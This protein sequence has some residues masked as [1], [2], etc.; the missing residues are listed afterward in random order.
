MHL[1]K[2]DNLTYSLKKFQI[3]SFEMDFFWSI[4][5]C[6]SMLTYTHLT[7]E[8]GSELMCGRKCDSYFE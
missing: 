5:C 6:Y 7:S 8:L 2:K 4:G 1:M 3:N